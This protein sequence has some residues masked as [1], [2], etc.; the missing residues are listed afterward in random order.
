MKVLV[1]GGAGYIGTAVTAELLMAGHTV[2]V[3][4]RAIFS[5]EPLLLFNGLPRFQLVVGDIRDRGAVAE[6][7][8]GID[9][10]VHLAALVGEEACRVDPVTT[11]A[12]N[13]EA[14]AALL[15]ACEAAGVGRLV[16]ISTCSNYGISSPSELADEDSSLQPLSLYARTK[17][18]AERDMLGFNGRTVTTVLRLGTICGLSGRMRFDL[19]I[20]DLARTAVRQRN[21]EIY[22]PDAWRP[23]LHVR[24]AARAIAHVLAAPEQAIN[25][26]VFN[27]IGE[28]LQKRVLA[29]M[30]KRHFPAA[31]ICITSGDSDNRDYRVSGRRAQEQLGFRCIKRV[32]DAFTECARA[33]AAGAFRD[34]D[35]PGHSAVPREPVHARL[36]VGK[37]CVVMP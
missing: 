21:I 22:K 26:Q 7:L 17:V 32:E 15:A 28:N 30:V 37:H 11:L 9:A 13:Q 18:T 6:S 23:F 27:V 3:L 35:W 12:I 25:R 29:E 14:S 31:T 36:E 2:R 20:G 34:A 1:T 8:S 33:V 4:D 16:F 19:L 24:D 10:V 5:L